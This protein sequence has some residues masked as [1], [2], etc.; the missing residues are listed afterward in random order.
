[1]ETDGE[2]LKNMETL[3]DGG[4]QLGLGSIIVRHKIERVWTRIHKQ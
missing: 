1:M 3:G 4:R 2:L